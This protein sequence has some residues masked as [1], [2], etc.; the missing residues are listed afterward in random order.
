MYDVLLTCKPDELLEKTIKVFDSINKEED[1]EKVIVMLWSR[2]SE[3][4]EKQEKELHKVGR[5]IR[6]K[7]NMKPV[8]I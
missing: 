8:K 1:A 3:L 4:T 5:K 7:F 6:K 2:V